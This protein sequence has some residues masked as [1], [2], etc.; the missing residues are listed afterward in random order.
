MPGDIKYVK[1]IPNVN[2]KN[3]MRPASPELDIWEANRISTAFTAHPCK[4]DGVYLCNGD[5]DCG[6]GP[7]HRWEGSCDKDGAD[8]NMYR[9]GNKNFYG[10]VATSRNITR[11]DRS[12]NDCGYNQTNH[13][14]YSIHHY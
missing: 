13:C 1:G 2:V 8:L 14:D 11:I 7:L 5:V 6:V 10:K 3:P 9:L 4:N 12:W